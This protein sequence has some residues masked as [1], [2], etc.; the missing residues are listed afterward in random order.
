M[1]INWICKKCLTLHEGEIG[2]VK[3]KEKC[4]NCGR[5]ANTWENELINI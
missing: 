1:K 5:I 3:L 2:N 4:R